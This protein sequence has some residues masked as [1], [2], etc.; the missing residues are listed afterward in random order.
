MLSSGIPW[1]VPQVACTFFV[2]TRAKRELRN[3][4]APCHGKYYGQHNQ[5]EIHTA[6]DWKVGCSTVK[7]TTDFLFSVSAWCRAH[8][9]ILVLVVMYKIVF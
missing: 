1:N 4:F 7:Y 6:R 2:Y 5:F 8:C 9:I 3:Y